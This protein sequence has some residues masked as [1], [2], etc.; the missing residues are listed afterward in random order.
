MQTDFVVDVKRITLADGSDLWKAQVDG[1]EITGPSEEALREA[2]RLD[3]I[4]RVAAAAGNKCTADYK[5]TLTRTWRV[6][7]VEAVADAD[8]DDYSAPFCLFD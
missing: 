8:A 1:R 3:I 6:R 7:V 4:G 2:V 5:A